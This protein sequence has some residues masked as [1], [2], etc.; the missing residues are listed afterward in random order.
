MPYYYSPFRKEYSNTF[1][2][3]KPTEP[4]PCPFCN[5]ENIESQSLRDHT[6]AIIENEYYRWMVNWF[7]RAEAH[8]MIMPKRHQTDLED[9]TPEETLA[10]QELTLR[11]VKILKQAF[12]DSGYEYFLQTGEG[13][14]GSVAHLHW[15]LVP[16]IP[17][18]SLKGFEKLGF[19]GTTE[20]AEEKLVISP[21]E[22]TIARE[23]LI[24]LIA[25][26]TKTIQE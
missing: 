21:I 15:H 5:T 24:E 4:Q 22:I 14:L 9:E 2:Q 8:T 19:Y 3:P 10:R 1:S 20:P 26:T 13:S 11:C 25:N 12:P 23:S 6:G 18:H 17:Q 16:T 7:P